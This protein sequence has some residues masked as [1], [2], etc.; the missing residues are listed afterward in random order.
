LVPY[1]SQERVRGERFY[2]VKTWGPSEDFRTQ[3]NY[4][5]RSSYPR[6]QKDVVKKEKKGRQPSSGTKR[7]DSGAQL[8]NVLD[9]VKK[10]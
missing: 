2:G 3:K 8:E 1:E 10:A 5:F 4:G 6:Q 7:I 9:R